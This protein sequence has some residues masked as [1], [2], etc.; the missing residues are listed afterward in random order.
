MGCKTMD[1]DAKAPEGNA[2]FI[3]GVVSDLMRA[4]GRGDEMD[5]IR[6]RMMAGDYDN[7]CDV[8]EEVSNGSIKV[9]NRGE[10]YDDG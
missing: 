9:V 2:W 1:I 6:K 4:T 7:L 3:M 5:A 10:D 8:A